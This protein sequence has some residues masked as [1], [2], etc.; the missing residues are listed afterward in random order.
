VDIFKATP[1]LLVKPKE[2]LLFSFKA[3]FCLFI[4]TEGLEEC[5]I[6]F[7]QFLLIGVSR[8]LSAQL[9][10]PSSPNADKFLAAIVIKQVSTL[11]L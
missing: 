2:S 6:L 8:A 1:F 3:I 10:P 9:P 7:W 11:L 4:E 5:H